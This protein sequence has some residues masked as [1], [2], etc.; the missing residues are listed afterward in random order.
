MFLGETC[1]DRLFVSPLVAVGLV[2]SRLP[3]RFDRAKRLTL[4][5]LLVEVLA[6]VFMTA[7]FLFS[8]RARRG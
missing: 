2:F 8:A 7:L 5:A 4:Y 3:A 6:L 1:L